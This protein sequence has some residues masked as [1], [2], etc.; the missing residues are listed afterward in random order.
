[1]TNVPGEVPPLNRYKKLFSN[2]LLFG[3]GTFSSKLLVF[4][5]TTFYTRVMTDAQ[6]GV[7]DLIQQTA[8]LLTPLASVGIL[9][10]V[11]RFGLD[12]SVSK[13]GVFTTGLCTILLGYGLLLLTWP[14]VAGVEMFADY[15]LLIFLYVLTSCLQGL[16]TQF[17]RAL[18]LVRL[19]AL[20]GVGRTITVILF[21]FLF[22]GAFQWGI[23]GYVLSTILSDL[24]SALFTFTV[25]RL[26]RFVR[27]RALSPALAGGMLRYCI[28]LIPTNIFWWIT[29]VS[30]RYIVT[31]Y[32]GDGQNG[33]LALAYK[34][35][36]IISLVSSIFMDAWQMS[37]VTEDPRTRERF[38]TQMFGAYQ[39]ALCLAASGLILFD[40]VLIRI[41]GGDGVFYPAWQYV[42]FLLVATVFSC[43]ASFLGSIYMV[44]KASGMAFLTTFIGAAMNLSLNLWWIPKYGVQGATIATLVSYFVVFLL[45]ALNSRRYM[46]I[47]FGAGRL[48]LNLAILLGQSLLLLESVPYLWLWEILLTLLVFLLNIRQILLT[49]Q[50]VLSRGKKRS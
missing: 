29:N 20:D 30:D 50:R 1:M 42:P 19:Y 41:M 5:M 44:Q 26:Y 31:Y 40:R 23:T 46:Y 39:A 18:G 3:L 22:L 43:M 9:N 49:L 28:P 14:L 7:V 37:A 12:K 16:C 8:N 38:F 36:T 32:L 21:N 33:V 10:A 17:V 6:F 11:I 15:T 25:A 48:L 47:R 34:L 2:T 24:L 13:H 45:R 4:L 27:L 35:P